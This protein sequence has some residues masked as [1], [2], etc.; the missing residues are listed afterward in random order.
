LPNNP[1]VYE[2]A[3]LIDRRQG[4]WA[5][6]TD[7]LERACEL[8]PRNG[9]YLVTLG[10]T[11]TWLHDYDQMARVIDRIVTLRPDSRIARMFRAGFEMFRRADTG[12][13]RAAI[14]KILTNEPGSD[15]DPF[16]AEWRLDLA[17]FD[18]DLDAA[19]SLAAAIPEKSG[20]NFWLGVV[21][22]LKGDAAAARAAFT[23]ARTE[24]EEQL[25]LHPDDIHLLS[26]LGLIDAALARKQEALSEGR[27]AM[28]LAPAAQET[29]RGW[30]NNEGFTRRQ[31]S[32]ICAWLGERELALDQ[33]QALSKIPG[34]PSYGELRLNPMWDPLR[35]DPR[36]ERIV[37]SSAPKETV[38]R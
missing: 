26:D 32:M 5:E 31:F 35:D 20:R 9:N 33:L 24:L 8:D 12:P 4:R 6:A 25:H 10:T 16:V 7:N 30:Y 18:R 29:M 36:F 14:E 17:L 23:T 37:A 38:S 19:G 15:R 2:L 11:Y 28:E 13:L 1:M 22:R 3:G 27:R 21:A 34:G